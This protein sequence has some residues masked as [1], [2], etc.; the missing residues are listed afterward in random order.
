VTD[1]HICRKKTH[2]W[3]V[4]IDKAKCFYDEVKITKK[5]TFSG[6]WLQNVNPLMQN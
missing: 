3:P 2:E 5:C 6:G 1:S 4:V